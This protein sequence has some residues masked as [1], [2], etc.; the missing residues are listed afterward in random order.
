MTAVFNERYGHL[1]R[2]HRICRDEKDACVEIR[3]E[4]LTLALSGGAMPH[5]IAL[6]FSR[7]LERVVRAH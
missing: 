3:H 5:N 6:L 4:R 2:D 7:P 1:E